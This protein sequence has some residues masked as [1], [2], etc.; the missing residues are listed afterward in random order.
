MGNKKIDSIESYIKSIKTLTENIGNDIAVVY[1][2]ENEFYPTF[3]QPNLFRDGYFKKNKFI[4]KNLLDE[5]KSNRLTNGKSYLEIAVDAQH[6]GFPSRLLDVT[7]N[8]LVALYFAVTPHYMKKKEYENDGKKDGYVYIYYIK[9]IFCPSSN[10]INELYNTILDREEWMHNNHIFQKNHKLI[11]HFKINDRIIAQQ[12]AFILFQGDEAY[13]IQ[14]SDYK[15]I[16]IDKDAREKIRRDL[17][18]LFG[19]HTGSIYPEINNLVNDIKL[20]SNKVNNAKFSFSS[21]LDLAISNLIRGLG[22]WKEEVVS[23]SNDEDIL[24]DEMIKITINIEKYINCYKMDLQM[25]YDDFQSDKNKIA[26]LE[27]II[28]EYNNIIDRFISYISCYLY[29]FKIEIDSDNLKI[30]ILYRGENKSC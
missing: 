27:D 29:S 2:G 11:D 10:N 13:P 16:I 22:Y 12:G 9:K 5:M 26:K 20:K 15:K 8:S 4:E 6:G 18:T 30:N 14:K 21:E 25:L 3:C 1:R 23:K 7:Y 28:Q 17:K 24:I 19:I